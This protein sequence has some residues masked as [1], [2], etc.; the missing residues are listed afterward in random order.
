MIRAILNEWIFKKLVR[1]EESLK[2]QRKWAQ[3]PS[4]NRLEMAAS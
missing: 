1:S 4:S 2:R 3:P